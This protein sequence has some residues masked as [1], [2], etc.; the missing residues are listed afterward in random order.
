MSQ[1]WQ[2]INGRLAGDQRPHD[3][4]IQAGNSAFPLCPRCGSSTD[5]LYHRIWTRPCNIGKPAY[6]ESL[7]L[8]PQAQINRE[9]QHSLWLRG[10]PPT[11][12][13]VPRFKDVGDDDWVVPRDVRELLPP[14]D[15]LD[16]DSSGEMF[17][18][19][20]GSGGRRSS[21]PRRRR[22]GAAATSM[23]RTVEG[24]REL[25]S[26]AASALAG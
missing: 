5:S 8:E 26:G 21:G 4:Q 1:C 15:A 24:G 16:R 14:L 19:R 11:S 12:L 2:A 9:T 7:A 10:V 6:T 13:T 23:R 22:V 18:F 25:L 17:A 3:R 20:D